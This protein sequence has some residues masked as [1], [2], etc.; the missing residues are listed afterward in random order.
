MKSDQA[1]AKEIVISTNPSSVL[2]GQAL[3]RQYCEVVVKVVMKRD[4]VLPRPY[5]GVEKMADAK[6]LTIAWPYN[7]VINNTCSCFLF[8]YVMSDQ[9]F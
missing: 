7:W 5:V 6:H 3:G 9:I 8:S 2:A 1:V 4:A